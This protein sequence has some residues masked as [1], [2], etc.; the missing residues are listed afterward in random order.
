MGSVSA[1]GV[2]ATHAAQECDFLDVRTI[3]PMHLVG[4]GVRRR[5]PA[6]AAA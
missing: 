6:A 4:T 5:W 1:H 2:S 3:G